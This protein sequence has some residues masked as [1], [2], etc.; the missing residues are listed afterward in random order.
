MDRALFLVMLRCGL[1]V[2]EVA[3]LKLDHIDW[4]HQ[5]LDIEQQFP[6]M[7]LPSYTTLASGQSAGDST[8]IWL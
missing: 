7:A 1:R 8:L 4:E 3:Q 2:S 5:A 6:P